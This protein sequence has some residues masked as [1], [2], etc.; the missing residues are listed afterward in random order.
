MPMKKIQLLIIAYVLIIIANAEANASSKPS[1]AAKQDRHV[2]YGNYSGVALLMDVYYPKKPNGYG[3]VQISGSG[4]TRPLSL[5]ADLLSEWRHVKF[6]S[7]P[8]LDAGYTIF[9]L[10]HR[11]TPRFKYPT[12][13]ADVQRAVRFIRHNAKKYNIN[14]DK[15]GAIGESSGGYLA[16]MLG[17]LNGYENKH[18]DNPINN[19]SAKVQ[20]VVALC[21]PMNLLGEIDVSF[22]LDFRKKEQLIK[23]SI[24]HQISVEASPISHVSIDDPPVLFIHSRSDEKVDYSQSLEMHNKLKHKGVLTKLIEINGA[25]H[26]FF[27]SGNR[28]E[29]FT[30]DFVKWMDIHLTNKPSNANVQ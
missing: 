18:D 3:I 10:N 5:D 19:L 28:V 22:Y 25:D 29:S 27:I 14:P 30:E 23:G 24:E 6:H 20:C 7:E 11:M 8:L 13:I 1:N 4:F 26:E 15:I 21:S 9:A 17:L 2:V 12:Q 16:S